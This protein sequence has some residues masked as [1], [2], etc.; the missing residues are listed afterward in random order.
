VQSAL[1]LLAK[2]DIEIWLTTTVKS[3]ERLTS[4]LIVASVLRNILCILLFHHISD[5]L[6]NSMQVIHLIMLLVFQV[7]EKELLFI[8]I[9][10]FLRTWLYN[11][12]FTAPVLKICRTP[13][14]TAC[15]RTKMVQLDKV[16]L[17]N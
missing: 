9:L 8:I 6:T 11:Y 4:R 1:K 12:C 16:C 10:L 2:S 15:S 17:K 13:G 14:P 5:P 7:N 3:S